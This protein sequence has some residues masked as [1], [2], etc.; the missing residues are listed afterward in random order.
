VATIQLRLAGV[1]I[2]QVDAVLTRAPLSLS[3]R[4]RQGKTFIYIGDAGTGPFAG[5]R[6]FLSARQSHAQLELAGPS[7]ATL[8]L[9]C[10]AIRQ[11]LRL[12]SH[13]L[14]ISDPSSAYLE[15]KLLDALQA[16][17]APEAETRAQGK[18]ED[19]DH[20]AV[21]DAFVYAAAL[22]SAKRAHLMT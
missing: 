16:S 13:A 1:V 17:L 22:S 21:S 7:Q 4:P 2:A 3:R 20:D 9:V 18:R 11:G 12:P 5:T 14:S 10:D 19:L 8:V 6:A 15:A